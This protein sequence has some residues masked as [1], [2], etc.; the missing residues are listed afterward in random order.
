MV[1]A[2]SMKN[3]ADDPISDSPDP[4]E[5]RRTGPSTE[6]MRQIVLSRP[7]FSPT[8][9]PIPL[10]QTVA[11]EAHTGPEAPTLAQV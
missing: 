8:R 2:N 6:A 9:L 7:L 4:M 11:E 3:D 1:V 10:E 5:P